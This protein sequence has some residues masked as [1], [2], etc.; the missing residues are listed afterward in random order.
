MKEHKSVLLKEVIDFLDVRPGKKYID[1]TI[2]GGGHTEAIL[3]AG[4]EVLGFDQ[5]PDSLKLAY[6]RLSLLQKQACP[7]R[8]QTVPVP[9]V[10]KLVH[11][12]FFRLR[13][14]V[15]RENF[16][17]VH[18]ALFDLGFASFQVDD[19]G[20]GLSFLKEGPLDMRLD[21]TLGVKAADLINGLSEKQ[22]AQ[23]FWEFG[24]ERASRVIAQ[25]IVKRRLEKHFE[26]TVE[27]A[28][29]VGNAKL[30]TGNE[31]RETKGIHPA[32]RVFMALRIVVNS[33]FENLRAALPQAVEILEEGGRLAVISFHSG[34]DRIVKNFIR[35]QA[36]RGFLKILTKKPVV[37]SD[38]ERGENP[39]ARSAKL[40][41]AEKI[42]SYDETKDTY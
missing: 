20:R 12:N 9:G 6:K 21:P 25:A 19:P 22:I 42:R 16:K 11:S 5:D 40:R 1:A 3:K 26:T 18:G 28:E 33:E 38:E 35:N 15:S 41:V 36:Q 37:A 4:G 13:E 32:T 10:F 23:L 34:E 30:K 2:G 29:L 27:L 8:Y 39:R 24:E 31:R 14:V 17:P 7:D